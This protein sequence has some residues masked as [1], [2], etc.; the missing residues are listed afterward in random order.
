MERWRYINCEK[1]NNFSCFGGQEKFTFFSI[2]NSLDM[3][4]IS[5][6]MLVYG[7]AENWLF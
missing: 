3:D 2:G 4:T 6:C 7:H 5:A 1:V